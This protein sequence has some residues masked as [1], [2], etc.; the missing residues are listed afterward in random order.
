[1]TRRSR[2]CLRECVNAPLQSQEAIIP[3]DFL[4]HIEIVHFDEIH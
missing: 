3:Q 4:R 1:M 2:S